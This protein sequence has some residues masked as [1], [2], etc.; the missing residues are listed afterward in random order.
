MKQELL[1]FIFSAFVVSTNSLGLSSSVQESWHA[2]SWDSKLYN[3]STAIHPRT[4]AVRVEV[5]DSRTGNPIR[6][7]RIELSGQWDQERLGRQEFGIPAIQ[8]KTF[9][10]KARTN[11][12][13]VAVFGLSWQKEVP[14]S[15]NRPKD[16]QP[17]G[18]W[19]Y[20]DSWIRP[21][22]DIEKVQRLTVR[23][24]DY[25]M[26]R[27]DFNFDEWTEFGQDPSTE[28]QTQE[29]HE[30]FRLGWENSIGNAGTKFCVLKLEESEQTDPKI[31][32]QYPIFF[33]KIRDKDYGVVFGELPNL[34]GFRI[35]TNVGPYFVILLEL[36]LE[37]A[38]EEIVIVEPSG[39]SFFSK[40]PPSNAK[41][42]KQRLLEVGREKA[43][44]NRERKA[45]EERAKL[46]NK[47]RG[48]AANHPLGLAVETLSKSRRKELGLAIGIK[49]V[50]I[51][52][53]TPDS[54]ANTSGL[55]VGDVISDIQHRYIADEGDF[56]AYTVD[57]ESGD[58]ISV[59]VWRKQQNKNWERISRRLRVE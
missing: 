5:V 20:A 40:D 54:P 52:F 34:S 49:G 3:W 51:L 38:R 10:L 17:N 59:T 47:L 43:R 56:H 25:I 15:L 22:D 27:G 31:N 6:N 42:E 29:I 21:M 12:N 50:E 53:A 4:V 9:T 57:L 33:E 55:Q 46:E 7:A 28:Y 19:T 58:A 14:W 13:G 35:P 32:L 24:S 18:S 45:K 8:E 41:D 26:I 44:M 1:T 39:D 48:E 2:G 37:P 36:E 11:P 16:H 30:S 23:H